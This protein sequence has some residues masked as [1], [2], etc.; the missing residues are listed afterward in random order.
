MLDSLVFKMRKVFSS[1]KVKLLS[2]G[3][4]HS[5]KYGNCEGAGKGARRLF[6]KIKPRC[7]YSKLLIDG[8]ATKANVV[9]EIQKVCDSDLAI[10]T[11]AGHGGQK[12]GNQNETDGK[13]EFL[14]LYDQPLVDNEIWNIVSKANGRVF[15]IF[16]CCHSE[17]MF[18]GF[19]NPMMERGGNLPDLLCWASCVENQVGYT[20]E[21]S[22]GFCTSFII[23]NAHWNFSYEDAWKKISNAENLAKHELVKQTLL[24]S[25]SKFKVEKLFS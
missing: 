13:D 16:D 25:D 20:V 24:R 19:E 11:Y 3:L 12:S 4:E 5:A 17:T 18:R 22:G 9:S 7:N 14:A 6:E 15:C 8:E 21:N 23:K 1:K 2:I 10:I